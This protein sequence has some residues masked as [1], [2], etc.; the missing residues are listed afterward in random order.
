MVRSLNHSNHYET[1]CLFYVA[2]NV[3]QN[4]LS[5]SCLQTISLVDQNFPTIGTAD[6]TILE[7]P[8]PQEG[9]KNLRPDTRI[10]NVAPRNVTTYA[11]TYASR[12]YELRTPTTTLSSFSKSPHAGPVRALDTLN[13]ITQAFSKTNMKPI[14]SPLR[15]KLPLAWSPELKAASEDSSRKIIKQHKLRA[16]SFNLLS[17]TNIAR[18]GNKFGT[19]PAVLQ[20]PLPRI[21]CREPPAEDLL[22]RTSC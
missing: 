5:L 11:Y 19:A 12:K 22:P 8:T 4:Y 17:P 18:D 3:S 20:D 10:K 1:I 13:M 9:P 16:K 14:H 7:T 6:T 21:Y 2:S 15:S